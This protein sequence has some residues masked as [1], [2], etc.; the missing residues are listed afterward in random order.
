MAAATNYQEQ[1]KLLYLE[2][3]VLTALDMKN[4]TSRDTPPY[5]SLKINRRFGGTC[6]NFQGRGRFE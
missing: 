6:L 3:D 4:V 5:V 2:F 1:Q